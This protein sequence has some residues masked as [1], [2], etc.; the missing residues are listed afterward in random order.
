MKTRHGFDNSYDVNYDVIQHNQKAVVDLHDIIEKTHNAGFTTKYCDLLVFGTG[1]ERGTYGAFVN[2]R[3]KD[4]DFRISRNALTWFT[5]IY[6]TALRNQGK[7]SRKTN[8]Y[9]SQRQEIMTV[10]DFFGIREEFEMAWDEIQRHDFEHDLHQ[11]WQERGHI[12]NWETRTKT[13]TLPLIDKVDAIRDAVIINMLTPENERILRAN[14][15]SKPDD[16]L[17]FAFNEGT[18]GLQLSADDAENIRNGQSIIGR[19]N[20][21]A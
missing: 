12:A 10:L 15:I 13:I 9:L 21:A 18:R 14:N 16:F 3:A 8:F 6:S 19:Y 1:A 7:T 20:V 11:E 4:M 2:L 17:Q 5:N